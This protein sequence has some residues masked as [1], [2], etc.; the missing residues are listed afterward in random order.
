VPTIAF[1]PFAASVTARVPSSAVKRESL[2][3]VQN[4]PTGEAVATVLPP[5]W[6]VVTGDVCEMPTRLPV[7]VKEPVVSVLV[8]LHTATY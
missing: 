6:K 7:S 2:A 3:S 8:P 5:T 4:T 1:V